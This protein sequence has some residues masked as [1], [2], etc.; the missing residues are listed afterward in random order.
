MYLQKYDLKR[1]VALVTGGGPMGRMGRID[2]IGAV[3]LFPASD[4]ASLLTGAIVL[5]DGGYTCW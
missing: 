2:E 4:A 1:R 3:A 5:A